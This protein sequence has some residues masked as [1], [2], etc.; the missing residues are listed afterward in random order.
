MG[1]RG[2]RPILL[3]NNGAFLVILKE[4]V[5]SYRAANNEEEETA[6]SLRENVQ[7]F[8][9]ISVWRSSEFAMESLTLAGER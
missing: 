1:R 9:T 3:F 6:Q 4:E 8:T 2:F 7:L 5:D